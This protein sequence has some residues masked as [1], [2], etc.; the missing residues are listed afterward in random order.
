[1]ARKK[2]RSAEHLPYN[3]ER[4]ITLTISNNVKKQLQELKTKNRLKSF[5]ETIELLLNEKEKRKRNF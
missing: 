2:I 4:K 5:S 3:P 1:M